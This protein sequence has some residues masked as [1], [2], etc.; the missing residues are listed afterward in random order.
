[1]GALANL[2]YTVSDQT[3]GNVLNRN[4]T[5]L[6]PKRS[7]TTMWNEFIQSHRAR[8]TDSLKRRFED[9]KLLRA[10]GDQQNTLPAEALCPVIEKNISLTAFNP[11]G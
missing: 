9:T 5:A 3:V 6:A 8:V 7:Q 2:G 11:L 10:R 4:G 1:M